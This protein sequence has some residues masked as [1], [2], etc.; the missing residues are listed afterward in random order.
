MRAS[1]SSRGSR[2]EFSS[3]AAVIAASV[4]SRGVSS[5]MSVSFGR[6]SAADR[7]AILTD[8]RAL[9]ISQHRYEPPRRTELASFEQRPLL[10][11]PHVIAWWSRCWSGDLRLGRAD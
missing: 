2:L 4:S 8:D 5:A 11:N 10:R 7:D 6:L 3:D 9:G 1:I